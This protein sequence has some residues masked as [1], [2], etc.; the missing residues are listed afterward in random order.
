MIFVLDVGN[1]R[2]KWGF[3]DGGNIVESGED[4]HPARLSAFAAKNW[5]NQERPVRAIISNVGKTSIGDRIRQWVVRHWEMEPQFLSSQATYGDVKN[6]Y[7][8]SSQLGSDRWAA[9]IAARQVTTSPVVII[10]CGSAITID[11][12]SAQGEHLGGLIIPGLEM[13]RTSLVKK[14]E[15][16]ELTDFDVQS[17]SFL[18]RDT[19][20]AV[21]GG[22]LYTASAAIDR[23][24]HD[25]GA[26]LG[27][28]TVYFIT[29]GD[30][31]QFLPLLSGDYHHRPNLVLE[32]LVAL[33][34]G[35]G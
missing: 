18:A 25:V 28:E 8:E 9:L 6:A 3:A 11:V 34:S 15:R 12:L 24:S 19:K 27:R 20:R 22:T 7:I 10:D 17:P 14:T 2:L 16:I 29:G 26:E 13:M 30:A 1:S 23:I 35:E 32:G 31:P 21:I 4:V 5:Q 33:A